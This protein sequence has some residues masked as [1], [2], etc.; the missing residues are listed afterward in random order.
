MVVG[1]SNSFRKSLSKHCPGVQLDFP[2]VIIAKARFSIVP[3]VS[4]R[5]LQVEHMIPATNVMAT[6]HDDLVVGKKLAAI[7]AAESCHTRADENVH[8]FF[9]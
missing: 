6:I 1:S 3:A 5:G 2:P 8:K 4:L 7:A 9:F